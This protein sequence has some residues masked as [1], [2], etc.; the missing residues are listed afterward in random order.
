MTSFL[1]QIVGIARDTW[2]LATLGETKQKY[3][4]FALRHASSE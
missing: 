2:I 1:P 3:A 4:A